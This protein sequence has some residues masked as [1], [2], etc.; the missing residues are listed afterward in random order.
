MATLREIRRR[1]TSIEKISQMT[2]AM[3]TVATVRLRR[4][5]ANIE[6]TR[7]Y[8][9]KLNTILGHLIAQIQDPSHPL[10]ETREA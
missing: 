9:D 1:I 10:L 7:P 4:A 5:Q 2:D 8:A 3:R 6:A